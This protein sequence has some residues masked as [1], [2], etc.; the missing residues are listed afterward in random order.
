MTYTS[1]EALLRRAVR[2]H[3]HGARL[4]GDRWAVMTPVPAGTMLRTAAVAGL[5]GALL[6]PPAAVAG[7]AP[8][9][10]EAQLDPGSGSP[11]EGAPEP[12]TA[13]PG[14]DASTPPPGRLGP[15]ATPEDHPP[16]ARSEVKSAVAT[17]RVVE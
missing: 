1:R 11:T 10:P 16:P 12:R 14:A 13:E 7:E 6:L 2:D 4:A 9:D 3:R 5:A 8:V 17:E 15:I